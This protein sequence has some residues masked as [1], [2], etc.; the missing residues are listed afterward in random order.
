MTRDTDRGNQG[1]RDWPSGHPSAEDYRGEA[2]TPPPPPFAQDWPEG[3]P[4]HLGRNTETQ[5]R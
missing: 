3:H 5:E 4:A 1:E 2:Y